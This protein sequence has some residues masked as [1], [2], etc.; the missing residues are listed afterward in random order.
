VTASPST[1]APA[2]PAASRFGRFDGRPWYRNLPLLAVACLGALAYVVWWAHNVYVTDP[3]GFE[4]LD[5]YRLGVLAWWHGQDMYGRLPLT[6]FGTRLP[7]VYP[8]FA[9]I[10]FS[11]LA[12][13]SWPGMIIAMLL[14]SLGGAAVVSYL[15]VRR[16]WPGGGIRG[17]LLATAALA[18]LSLSTEPMYD[19]LWFGQINLLLMLLVALDCLVLAPRWPRGAL[20]GIAAAIKLTPA[21][22]LL[23]FLLRKDWR[24]SV[25]IL[26]STAVA[27]ALGFLVT[28]R[29]SVEYWFGSMGAAGQISGTGFIGNQSI[30]GGLGRWGL[31]QHEQ[32]LWWLTLVVVVGAVAVLGIRRAHRLGE[33]VLALSVTAGFGLLASPVS[34]GHY[35]IYVI[36]AFVVMAAVGLRRRHVGWLLAAAALGV[37]VW[38]PPFFHTENGGYVLTVPQQLKANGYTLAVLV[39]LVAWAVP[40][41]VRLARRRGVA[42]GQ[43]RRVSRSESG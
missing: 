15:C 38:I 14:L 2:R 27:T 12:L 39:L 26:V 7:F 36:P 17:A 20:I 41:I 24:T 32:N 40:E 35:Y 25:T 6:D 29:E 30:D 4:D 28:W 43:T 9:A 31:P 42:R 19:T 13:L 11:P 33:P 22:F 10:V 16:A 18:P 23:Y 21:V 34:W 3:R 5:A 37:V 1:T 8:P